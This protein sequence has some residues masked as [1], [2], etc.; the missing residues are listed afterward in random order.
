MAE[1]SSFFQEQ[2]MTA[3]SRKWPS[4][5][6]RLRQ[7]GARWP[8]GKNNRTRTAQA[9]FSTLIL[10]V[11][12]ALLASPAKTQEQE[13]EQKGP[14]TIYNTPEQALVT[15]GT[16]EKEKSRLVKDQAARSGWA[17][18]ADPADKPGAGIMWY[19]YTYTQG[20]GRIRGIFRLKVAD[21]T[22]PQPV[23]TIRG[24]IANTEIKELSHTYKEISLKGTDFKAPNKYQEFDLEI[25]KGEKGFG[26]WLLSTTGVTTVW[27][28]GLAVKQVSRFTT[29]QLL[30]LIDSP[31]KPA[32]LALESR[33]FRVHETYGIFM[34]QWKVKEAMR[35][36]TADLP[37]TERTQSHLIVHS[38]NT[39]LTGFPDKWEDLYGHP[40]VVLNNVPAKAVSIVGTIMLKQYV[41][42][43][44]CLIMMGDTHGLVPG[45]WAQSVLGPLLPVTPREYRDLEYAATPL[46]LQTTD[47]ALREL[48]WSER[49]YT[50]YYHSADVR[51]AAS[52]LVSSGKIPLIVQRKTGQGR[53]VVLL[54]S[55]F[56]DNNPQFDGIPFWEWSDWPKLMAKVMAQASL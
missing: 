9:H 11:A 36:V 29:D 24:N 31:V 55:V 53:I 54:T 16:G 43:G 46:L 25:L 41:Q 10:A 48:N 32:G 50:I 39:R 3:Y 14:A 30:P 1:N 15:T 35:V 12:I 23:L 56:G 13:G 2:S 47:D 44:G 42:D 27:Y 40:V 22:S 28:D 18:K 4:H 20:P 21:N 19:E 45:G 34:P 8:T 52:V 26:D 38:Q 37:G 33:V 7:G 49:P 6:E 5:T 17:I 51:P